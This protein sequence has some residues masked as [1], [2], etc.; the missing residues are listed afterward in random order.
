MLEKNLRQT[1]RKEGNEKEMD[2]EIN[3]FQKE[4]E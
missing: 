4:G 1:G 2:V 3:D